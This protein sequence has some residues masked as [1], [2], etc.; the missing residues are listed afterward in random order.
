MFIVQRGT[1][2]ALP[3]NSHIM[4]LQGINYNPGDRFRRLRVR[5]SS[6]RS[7]FLAGGPQRCSGTARGE[8]RRRL[9]TMRPL[10]PTFLYYT[11]LFLELFYS[12]LFSFSISRPCVNRNPIAA[13]TTSNYTSTT[14]F[15]HES[16]TFS[17]ESTMLANSDAYCTVNS[18]A[19]NVLCELQAF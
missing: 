3:I 4:S 12:G 16:I 17:L 14:Y 2:T 5:L 1:A 6:R 19:I 11:F 7:I 10:P 8:R 9:H 18:L 13:V 15:Y